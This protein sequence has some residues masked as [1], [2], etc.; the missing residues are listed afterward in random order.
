MC[1]FYVILELFRVTLWHVDSKEAIMLILTR[2]PQE[3]VLINDNI[4]VQILGYQGGQ[5]KI[6][7]TAPD[8]VNVVR[9][10]LPQEH[11]GNE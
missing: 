10:E 7:I 11:R 5:V 1:Y 2:K 8:D 3:A 4:E 9:E 6:G